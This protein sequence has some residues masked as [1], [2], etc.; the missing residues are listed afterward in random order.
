MSES[1]QNTKDYAPILPFDRTLSEDFSMYQSFPYIRDIT[2][3]T[4]QSIRLE[5]GNVYKFYRIAVQD[6]CLIG[7]DC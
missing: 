3:I 4:D 1:N 7:G 5:S 6:A 2:L